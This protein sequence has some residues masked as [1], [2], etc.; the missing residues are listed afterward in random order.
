MQQIVASATF[1]SDYENCPYKAFR[2]YVVRD[3]PW[4]DTPEKA[5]GNHVH[6]AMEQRL[7]SGR[8]LPPDLAHLEPYPAAIMASGRVE[9]EQQVACDVDFKPCNYYAAEV[10]YRGKIDVTVTQMQATAVILDWKTGKKRENPDE[11]ELHALLLHRKRPEIERV[12]AHYV[13]T[14]DNEL[15]QP[16]VFDA[17]ERYAQYYGTK[18]RH[19]EHNAS[20]D[21]W[22][23]RENPLCGWCDVHDCEF[24]RKGK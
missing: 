6:T 15:G 14:K 11:L 19:V 10:R 23:K 24:N 21:H 17:F 9:G 8:P 3:L 13:W 12:V 2:R 1:F 7:V 18:L 20:M 16:Y 4:I 22:P 5:Y